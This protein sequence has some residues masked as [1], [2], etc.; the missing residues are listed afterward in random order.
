MNIVHFNTLPST[1]TY[2]CEQARG[3]ATG[4]VV[5]ADYQSAGRGQ[6]GNR[7]ESEAG[8]NLLFSMLVRQSGLEARRQFSVSEGVSVALVRTLSEVCGVECKVKWPNDIYAGEKKIC[9]ILISHSVEAAAEAGRAALI[10]HSVIGAGVN[11]N[12]REFRSD[13]PNPVSVFQLT[14]RLTDREHFLTEAVTHINNLLEQNRPEDRERLHEEYMRLL[15]R[16]EGLPHEFYDVLTGERFR[17][18]VYAVE[19]MGHLVLRTRPEGVLRRY[20]FKE[21]AWL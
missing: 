10:T 19:P 9:G 1:Y 14:G 21:V 3:M 5:W 12:Q 15:W 11:L 20:A 13:A 6:R 16:G 7:W 8:S 17:A 2:V 4:T 18:S